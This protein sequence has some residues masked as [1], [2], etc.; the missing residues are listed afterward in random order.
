MDLPAILSTALL[1][2]PIGYF[3]YL[4]AIGQRRRA[5]EFLSAYLFLSGV[6]LLTKFVLKIPR[7]PGAHT[8]FDPY[9]FPSFHTAYAS[10][11]FFILPN[12]WTFA[13]AVLVG[14]LRVAAGVHRWIDVLGAFLIA[15]FT[16]WLYRAGRKR[17]GFEWDRQSF[18]MGVGALIGLILYKSWLFG[19]WLLAGALIAGAILYHFRDHDAIRPF[20]EFFDRDGTGKGA[21][22]FVI[23]VLAA[24]AIN[25]SWGWIS[26]WYVAYVDS[27][28]TMVGKWFNTRGKSIYGTLGGLFAGFLVAIATNTPLWLPL[29]VSAVELIPKIDDNISIP[30]VVALVG[31]LLA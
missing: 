7:P 1:I 15:G 20:L 31:R 30:I 25:H 27:T 17:V 14:Y 23:G 26:A 24:T 11:F 10:L 12:V 5:M 22:Y 2:V 18:H 13:Y 4:F 6:V 9:S 21:F 29:L 16:L 19:F 8:D 3:V 28:A